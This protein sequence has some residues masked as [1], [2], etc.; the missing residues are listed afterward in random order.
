MSTFETKTPSSSMTFET[1]TPSSS[2]SFDGKQETVLRVVH[3]AK[4]KLQEQTRLKLDDPKVQDAIKII[5][6]QL[7]DAMACL[8]TRDLLLCKIKNDVYSRCG[9][10]KCETHH[11]LIDFEGSDGEEDDAERKGDE[12][13]D[14]DES[15]DNTGN[16]EEETDSSDSADSDEEEDTDAQSKDKPK[17]LDD[18]KS[19]AKVVEKKMDGDTKKV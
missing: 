15:D 11:E 9:D 5:R 17:Q 14:E 2:T 7:P 13:D 4:Q 6:D 18:S 19:P 12:E 1:K 8:L 16:Q 10:P 3:E